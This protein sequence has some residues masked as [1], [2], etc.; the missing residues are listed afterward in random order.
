MCQSNPKPEIRNPKLKTQNS[1]LRTQNSELTSLF[2]IFAKNNLQMN[3]SDRN[4]RKWK[5]FSS[6][7]LNFNRNQIRLLTCLLTRF[8][9]VEHIL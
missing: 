9:A 1:E 8:G 7:K 4:G 2:I 3:Y 6:E 5:D